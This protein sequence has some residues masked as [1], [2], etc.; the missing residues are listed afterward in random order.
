MPFICKFPLHW[1]GGGV[2]RA[3]IPVKVDLGPKIGFSGPPICSC[4]YVPCHSFAAST[5]LELF[6]R[7]LKPFLFEKIPRLR[8]LAWKSGLV[9]LDVALDACKVM[10]SLGLI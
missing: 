3:F 2:F 5:S 8:D 9:G 6:V 10:Q 4:L 1:G 7:S